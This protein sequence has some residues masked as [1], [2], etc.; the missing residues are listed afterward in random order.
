MNRAFK[1]FKEK[2]NPSEIKTNAERVKKYA[3]LELMKLEHEDASPEEIA[4][5]D[6]LTSQLNLQHV[7]SDKIRWY[8]KIDQY[9]RMSG[10]VLTLIVISMIMVI[11]CTFFML[12]DYLFV[13]ILRILPSCFKFNLIAQRAIGHLLLLMSGFIIIV[14]DQRENAT[15]KKTNKAAASNP[16]GV[17]FI[18]QFFRFW[19]QWYKNS[20]SYVDSVHNQGNVTA[21]FCFT[22]ASTLEGFVLPAVTPVQSYTYVSSCCCVACRVSYC[23]CIRSRLNC[24]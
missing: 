16:M 3:E 9:I 2:W 21:M 18:F 23:W 4:Q 17:G 6:E 14:D 5:I 19:Y 22:H 13:D 7:V 12:T 11:P 20:R 15:L 1:N 8:H 24:S 10:A